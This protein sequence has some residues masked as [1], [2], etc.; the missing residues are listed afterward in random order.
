[1][2]RN[3]LFCPWTTIR[4]VFIIFSLQCFFSGKIFNSIYLQDGVAYSYLL[5]VLAPEHCSPATLDA[6]DPAER[7]K[8]VLDHAE[9]MDCKRYLSPKDIV[10]GSANLNLAF[11]AQIFQQRSACLASFFSLTFLLLPLLQ[12]FCSIF[13]NIPPPYYLTK[14]WQSCNIT[15]FNLAH[16]QLKR[17][18]LSTW[19][20]NYCSLLIPIMDKPWRCYLFSLFPCHN[21]MIS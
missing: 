7:A 2:M 11:V 1:M 15:K 21:G 20:L 18:K 3:C 14:D 6:K 8:L 10:E 13:V 17:T 12:W 16:K 5:N 19:L 4:F 9:K